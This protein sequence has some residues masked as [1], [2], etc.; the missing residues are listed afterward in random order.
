MIRRPPRSPLFPY[1]PLFRS[2]RE[3]R[4]L[5]PPLPVLGVDE[6]I[7]A[8]GLAPQH[9]GRRRDAMEPL[10]EPPVGDRPDEL[11]H[12]RPPLDGLDLRCDVLLLTGGD[13]GPPARDPR[14]RIPE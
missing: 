9:E 5:D 11:R 3:R 7:R 10:L 6:G 2:E 8:V 13:P 14:G 4:P 12:R 1:P